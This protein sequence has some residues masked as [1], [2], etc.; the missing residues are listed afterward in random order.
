MVIDYSLVHHNIVHYTTRRPIVFALSLTVR[1]D[2]P[3]LHA[4]FFPVPLT[5]LQDG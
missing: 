3:A 2:L 5:F 4:A 1:Q